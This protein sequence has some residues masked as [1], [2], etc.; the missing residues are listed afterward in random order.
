M[1]K[2]LGLEIVS[3]T[4]WEGRAGTQHGLLGGVR[5]LLL[6]PH[7]MLALT[8]LVVYAYTPPRWEDWNQNSR[9]DLTR[10]IVEQG[11]LR[12]DDY[13]ENTGDYA[14]LDGHSYTDKAPGLSLL[15]V[16]VYALTEALGS[17]GLDAL[18]QRIAGSGSFQS[19]LTPGGEGVTA[20]RV[21]VALSLTIATLLI[22]SLPAVLMLVLLAMIV[23][24]LSGCRTAGILTALIMGLATPITPYAQAFYGHIPAAACLVGALALLALSTGSLSRWS[25]V[26]IGVLLGLA[27]VIEYPAALVAL[28]IALWAVARERQR[29]VVYGLLGA[30]PALIILVAYDLL[31]FGTLLPVGYEHSA[32]WQDQHSAGFMS[33]TYPHWDAIWGLSFS[34]YRG[35]FFFSPVLLLSLPGIWLLWR[36]RSSRPISIVS[37]VG[38]ALTFLFFASSIMWWGGFA[39]GPRYLVPAIPM[40]AIPL[41]ATIAAINQSPARRRLSGLVL[42][43]ILAAVSG[44]LTWAMTL[45]GQN[46]PPDTIHQPLNDYVWPAIQHGDIARNL[47]MAGQLGGLWSL[48]PIIVLAALGLSLTLRALLPARGA[49]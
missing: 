20:E 22:V 30:L 41:G 42:L 44:L 12:I 11:T 19:T 9:F 2:E 13:V 31:A 25:L 45:A 40:L 46:Y 18:A 36:K 48:L 10:A 17:V 33:I 35:L 1:Q 26:G 3:E 16:P 39:A 27:M 49:R 47:G 23:E 43:A 14:L 24:R 37:G 8:L 29:A 7:L 4:T 34:S 28:P 21:D 5:R 38:F 6:S 32:L 15:A